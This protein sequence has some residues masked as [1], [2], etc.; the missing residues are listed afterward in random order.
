[1]AFQTTQWTLV[2]AAGDSQ[3]PDSRAALAELCQGYWYPLYVYLR[4]RGYSQEEAEDLV[5]GFFAQLLEKNYIKAADKE[6]GR[7]RSF[8]L[9]SLKNYAANEWDRRTAV[10]RGGTTATLSLDFEDAEGRYVIEPA[11]ERTP[12]Q[13]FDRGWAMAQLHRVLERMRS[14][15]GPGEATERFELLQGFLTGEGE[16]MPYK[17]VA[18]RLG[19]SEGAVKVAVHRLRQRFGAVLR[20]EVARTLADPDDVDDEIRHLFA[21]FER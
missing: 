9:A 3:H 19:M 15:A 21:A 17:E 13:E 10:K 2:V 18:E 4:R 20:D 7:F 1:M 16:D 8:L 12:E 14:E 5:Q 6:R 11:D